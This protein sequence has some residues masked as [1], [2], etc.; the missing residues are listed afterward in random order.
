MVPRNFGPATLPSH[1]S[2]AIQLNPSAQPVSVRSVSQTGGLVRNG[3]DS[4][5]IAAMQT[6]ATTDRRSPRCAI[7]LGYQGP[8]MITATRLAAVTAPM[9]ILD[10]P[11]RLKTN[12]INGG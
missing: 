11:A 2:L 7:N 3:I 6:P 4:R 12:A 10:T 1:T 8:T 5:M 9:P